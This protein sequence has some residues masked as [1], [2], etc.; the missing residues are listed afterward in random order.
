MPLNRRGLLASAGVMLLLTLA[1]CAQLQTPTDSSMAPDVGTAN[2]TAEPS[3]QSGFDLMG[4]QLALE[5]AG[6][7][8]VAADSPK[9]SDLF[10]PESDFSPLVIEEEAI[11][12]YTFTDEEAAIKAAAG[13]APDGSSITIDSSETRSSVNFYPGRPMHFYRR[14][15]LIALHMENVTRTDAGEFS[16]RVTRVLR[17]TMGPQFAGQ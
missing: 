6:L 10:G 11:Y 3:G 9:K 5:R 15:A 4:L 16:K 8:V 13:V 7:V 17:E 1:G 12:V 14:E 2:V